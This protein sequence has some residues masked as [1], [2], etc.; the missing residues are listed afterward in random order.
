MVRD[1]TFTIP[2]NPIA[3]KRHRSTKTGIQYDP[4]KSDKQDFLAKAMQ[5][6]PNKPWDGPVEVYMTFVFA[7]PKSH[8]RTGR[9]S[10]ELK[11]TSLC[12]HTSRPDFDNL[13]KFVADALNSVFWLDDCKLYK[14]GWHKR[15]ANPNEGPH[16][17]IK[18]LY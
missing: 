7:R 12:P 8:Y 14:G 5:H 4:S 9:Y 15:Y 3:L 1:I 2:G 6:R 16:I 18:I 10:G 13:L 17:A 11:S